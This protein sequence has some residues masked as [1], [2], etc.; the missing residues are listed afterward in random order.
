V[1]PSLS[2]FTGCPTILIPARLAADQFQFRNSPRTLPLTR[3]FGGRGR[4]EQDYDE[5]PGTRG[6]YGGG[7]G[8]NH[9]PTRPVDKDK[10]ESELAVCIKKATSP[11]ETAPSRWQPCIVGCADNR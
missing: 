6:A 2:L 1:G 10:T 8:P 5:G 3:R 9:Q 7:G 11:E 4:H